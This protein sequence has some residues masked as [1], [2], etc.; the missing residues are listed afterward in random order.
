NLDL[1][2]FFSDPLSNRIQFF[3]QVLQ[4]LLDCFRVNVK[5]FRNIFEELKSNVVYS[6]GMIRR[7]VVAEPVCCQSPVLHL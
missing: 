5:Q 3:F 7:P 6:V 2:P 4:P 1:R